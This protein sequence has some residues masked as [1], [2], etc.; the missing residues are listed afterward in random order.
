[1]KSFQTILLIVFAFFI[2]GAVLIFSGVLGGGSGSQDKLI[3]QPVIMWG[4]VSKSTMEDILQKAID[5]GDKFEITYV[6]KRADSFEA[7]LIDALASNKGPDLILAPHTLVLKQRDKLLPLPETAFSRR[8]FMDSFVEAGETLLG[9]DQEGGES[10]VLGLPLFLD[11][12]VMY[13][14][15]DMFTKA[16]L[17]APPSTWLEVQLLPERL[18]KLD[19]RGNIVEGAVGLGG[20]NNVSHFKEILSAQIMQT[21]NKIVTFALGRAS[22]VLAEGTNAESALRFYS[23]FGNPSLPKYSWNSAKRSSLDEFIAGKLAIYFGFGSELGIIEARNPHL[24]FDTAN[25]P[26]IS[27]GE[28]RLTYAD[29]YT[30]AVIKNSS[31]QNAAYAVAYRMSLGVAADIAGSELRLPP[32]RRD[33]LSVADEDPNVALFESAAVISKTWFDPNWVVT[34]NIFADMIE[35]VLIGK[36]SPSSAVSAASARIQDLLNI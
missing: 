14:N 13:W 35:S 16:G 5:A 25:F 24:N 28:R 17:S 31:V 23:E 33:L 20:V 22:V 11:P 15:R 6:E 26:Q 4:T 10:I 3:A 19:E 27:S 1:M 18:T 12:I 30:L 36:L 21:G 34:R 7:E 8:L 9:T 29:V 2:V 32:A